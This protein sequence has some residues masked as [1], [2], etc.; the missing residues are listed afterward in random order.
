MT[1]VLVT[2]ANGFVGKH[3]CRYLP[4]KGYA[5]RAAQ[6]V[7]QPDSNLAEQVA[8]GD[9]D[10]TTDWS[11]ALVGVDTVV[12]L[13]ARVHVMRESEDDP[14]AAFR[15]VNVEG[16]AALGRQAVAAGV[17]RMIYLSSIKVNGEK[18][19]GVPFSAD[20]DAGP[21]DAYG[22]SKWEAEQALRQIALETGLE[23][24][25]IRPVVI[26]GAGVKGNLQRLMSLIRRGVPLPLGGIQNR[27]SFLSVGNL[28]DFLRCAIDHPAAA[29]ELFLLADG[30]DLSTPQL[31]RKLSKVMGCGV[32]LFPMPLSLLQFAGWLTGQSPVIARLTEDLQVDI[33]KNRDRLDWTPVVD[34]DQALQEM[35]D[36]N[37][38][39]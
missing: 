4:T 10:G 12:H 8:I 22:I 17:R 18:T 39:R 16:T 11:G 13:A 36:V 5:V 27:R 32:K 24:V 15:R 20:D 34:M 31:I 23:L 33:A 19:H 30:E 28:L 38:R 37:S 29:G 25:I 35:V 26:Y 2:G 6:R 1:T 9:I 7:C 3:L 21:E 14:L